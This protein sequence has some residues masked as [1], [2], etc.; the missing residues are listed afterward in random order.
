MQL[1]QP[2]P[3]PP[4][5]FLWGVSTSGYQSEGGYNGPHD[6]KNNWFFDEH[7]GSVMRTGTAAEFWTRYEEDFRACQTIGL[8]AFRLGLEWAR[9]QPSAHT[10]AASAPAFDHAA[11]DAYA[12]RI[13]ACRQH[14][15]EPIVTLHHF[16]HP[17]WLGMDAWLS[18]ETVDCFVEY[19]RVAVTQINRRLTDHYQLPPIHWYITVNE[20]NMLVLNTYLSRQ[21]PAGSSW[22]VSAVLH[23]YSYMLAAH[24]RAYN[25]IHDIYEAE[26][27]TT[28]RVSLNTYCSD[29]YWSE[30]VIWDLLSL[31]QREVKPTQLESYT[32]ANAQQL[33][34]ALCDANLPFSRDLPYQI[35]QLVYRF[36]NWFCPS[37]FRYLAAQL[38]FSR[39]RSLSPLPGV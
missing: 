4:E 6:P 5:T 23:A 24:I 38:F 13:A 8:N 30:K 28:P 27:W 7:R 34:L 32:D 9:I 39:T 18:E 29:H 31:R 20:P 17:A 36:S 2:E 10:G 11:L 16:T 37:Q 35:G 21:F 33:K 3:V 1:T 25:C 12:D 15:L 22:G 19:V 14:G 26:G